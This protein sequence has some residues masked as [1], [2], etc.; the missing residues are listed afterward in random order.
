MAIK[1]KA[2]QAFT[3][4]KLDDRRIRM[5]FELHAI[6]NSAR[7]KWVVP[8]L[9]TLFVGFALTFLIANAIGESYEASM[10]MGTLVWVAAIIVAT[11]ISA[12]GK[13][14]ATAKG[15]SF[16]SL[17]FTKDTVETV[18][19]I[20]LDRSEIKYVGTLKPDTDFMYKTKF[21]YDARMARANKA[22]N[23]RCH[24]YVTYGT[25]DVML[26]HPSLSPN[27]AKE[28]FEAIVLWHSDP[29][30]LFEQAEAAKGGDRTGY[31]AA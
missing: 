30:A 8:F 7:G 19:A 6:P 3:L 24:V 4:E 31:A 29:D 2:D 20:E 28:I 1:L 16:N 15:S 26:T 23:T 18:N 11:N 27:Q 17:I 14:A 21:E 25:K 22:V 10:L 9:L 13:K 12:K 5:N